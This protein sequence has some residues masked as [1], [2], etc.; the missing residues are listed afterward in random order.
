M[1][2]F[3][4]QVFRPDHGQPVGSGLPGWA[5]RCPEVKSLCEIDAAFR[6]CVITATDPVYKRVLIQKA[7]SVIRGIV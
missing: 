3:H 4:G 5:R 6:N 2:Q 7:R 1:K